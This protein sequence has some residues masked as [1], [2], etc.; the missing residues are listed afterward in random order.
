VLERGALA[1]VLVKSLSPAR[2]ARAALG[3]GDGFDKTS[4]YVHDPYH[5]EDERPFSGKH[6]KIE[7][8]EFRRMKRYGTDVQKSMII[9][10]RRSG[11]RASLDRT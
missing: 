10:P 5:E 11:S 3:A 2:N 9:G 8:G 1:I 4:V 6:L 7:R